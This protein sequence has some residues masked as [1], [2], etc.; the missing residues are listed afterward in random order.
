MN[1]TVK[2]QVGTTRSYNFDVDPTTTVKQLKRLVAQKT[3]NSDDEL[4]Y[5]YFVF[6]IDTLDE[7][8]ATLYSYGVEDQSELTLQ[9]SNLTVRNAGNIGKLYV[10]VCTSK[11]LRRWEWVKVAPRWR[12][13]RGGLC[14][15]GI[16]SNEFCEACDKT[17]IMPIG[18]KR[19]D[20]LCDCNENTTVCPVCKQYVEP[21]NCAFNNCWWI[22]E[23][24]RRD[25]ASR[26][27]ARKRFKSQWT[28]ADNAYNYFEGSAN[29][30]TMWYKLIIEA[31]KHR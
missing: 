16:C 28:W 25:P 22:Y 30:T 5:M 3:D 9:Y 8:E 18:Y 11:D 7:D 17:V 29:G 15:E 14:L 26:N 6:D 27:R 10:D 19:F 21:T 1:I 13:A 4:K 23:G 12:I 20:V 2:T 24:V 31:V